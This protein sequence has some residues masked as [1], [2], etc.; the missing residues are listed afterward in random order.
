MVIGLTISSDRT[1]EPDRVL[2]LRNPLSW[3]LS[4]REG[5]TSS[6]GELYQATITQ[7][8]QNFPFG[9]GHKPFDERFGVAVGSHSTVLGL[10]LRGGVPV[11]IMGLVFVGL[12]VWRLLSRL[13]CG[14]RQSRQDIAF[15]SACLI[16]SLFWMITDDIDV[17]HEVAF[18]FFL[19]AALICGVRML[20]ES[21]SSERLP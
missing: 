11:A 3:V 12:L 6:R 4:A 10:L 13:T 5:S 16:G 1:G 19:A 7:T 20:P 2:G 9:V 8:V 18:A 21:S 17:T 14:T 15:L